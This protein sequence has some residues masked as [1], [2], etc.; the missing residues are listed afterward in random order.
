MANPAFSTVNRTEQVKDTVKALLAKIYCE[1]LI[2]YFDN[3]KPNV[4][5]KDL[6]MVIRDALGLQLLTYAMM[7]ELKRRGVDKTITK[8][9]GFEARGF[10]YGPLIAKELNVGFVMMR[11]K[12]KLPG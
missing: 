6:T 3:F 10:I 2:Q 9:I 8:V 4:I 11:K 1:R 5:F 7:H 12:G